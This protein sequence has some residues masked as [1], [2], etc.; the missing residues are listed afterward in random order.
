MEVWTSSKHNIPKHLLD[1]L[2]LLLNSCSAKDNPYD[3]TEGVES[4]FLTP[5]TEAGLKGIPLIPGLIYATDGSQ[6][7]GNMGAGFYRHEGAKGCF[8]KVGREEEGASSNRAEHSAACITLELEDAIRYT[9]S[10]RPLILLTDSKCLLMA[11]QKWIG[12]GID[13]TIKA[14]P[15]GDILREI[16]ELLRK[17]IIV[18]VI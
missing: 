2:E 3:G 6:E 8:G 15:D 17:R 12:E 16:L 14:S 18:V 9:E 5:G 4:K 13:R 11:N 10:Q 1:D 7:K